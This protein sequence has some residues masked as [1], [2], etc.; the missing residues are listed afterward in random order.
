MVMMDRL[1]A[2]TMAMM[3]IA[4][5][6]QGNNWSTLVTLSMMRR[7]LVVHKDNSAGSAMAWALHHGGRYVIMMIL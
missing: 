3:L 2:T 4:A 7:Y 6:Q 5:S 1:G